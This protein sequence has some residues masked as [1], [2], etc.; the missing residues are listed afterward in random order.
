MPSVLTHYGFN[1]EVLDNKL[2]FL[3]N[4]EDI[5]LLGAQGPD[6]F[7][8]YGI[9]PFCKNK[10][11]KKVRGYG[12]KLHKIAPSDV[13][14][15]FFKFADESEAKDVLYSYILGAGLHYVLDRK[16]HPYVYYKTGFSK[17]KKKKR[18]YYVNHTLLETNIDVLLMEGIFKK[19]KTNPSSSI[20]SEI[21]KVD[22]VSKM[23]G[24]LAKELLKED[25]IDDY[26]FKEAYKQMYR[27]E[28]LLYSKRGIKKGFA[29]CLFKNTPLNTMM[30]PKFVK[31]DEK[32]DYLN[33]KKSEWKD[34][35]LE[36]VYIKS[37]LDL[38]EE[39]KIDASE[40]T[41]IVSEYYSNKGNDIKLKNFIKGII[42]DGYSEGSEMKVFENVFE[43]GERSK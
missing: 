38:I 31:D 23:Y 8:F 26:S 40:W 25:K 13:F 14:L 36:T 24:K 3:K 32:I 39:A 5:Y 27:L 6:P 17:D 7:F 19:Y 16:L 15:L 22:Y 42:Y 33:L 18:R 9:I 41:M 20:K 29:N 11:A 12:S 43:K 4:N 35:T 28:K 30:H 2:E 34:P 10:N 1:K 21:N 37:V